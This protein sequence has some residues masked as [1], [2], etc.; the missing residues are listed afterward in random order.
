MWRGL[1]RVDIHTND[2]NIVSHLRRLIITFYKSPWLRF[3][4]P[5]SNTRY[6]FLQFR[7]EECA[8]QSRLRRCGNIERGVRYHKQ[9]NDGFRTRANF[10]M[11]T[12]KCNSNITRAKLGK[13]STFFQTFPRI[14]SRTL[15]NGLA[16]SRS[17]DL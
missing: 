4:V 15:K 9:A 5:K 7:G 17:R 13:Y 14:M 12:K 11:Q 10:K 2:R 1:L 6:S 8:L 3:S 16:T